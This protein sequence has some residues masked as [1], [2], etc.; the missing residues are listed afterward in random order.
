[1]IVTDLK[2]GDWVHW[3]GNNP[4]YA[5]IHEVPHGSINY[6]K[7]DVNGKGQLGSHNGCSITH[8]RRVK[9]DELIEQG[10]IDPPASD[11]DINI[12]DVL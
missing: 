12:Y 5:K 8:L 6:F 4:V 3:S 1:M 2:V 10:L 9:N 11:D 7:L